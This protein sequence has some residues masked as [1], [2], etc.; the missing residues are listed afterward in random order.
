MKL[1]FSRTVAAL[2]ALAA[3][4]LAEPL[5]LPSEGLE[6]R[7]EFWKKV[8]TQYGEDDIIVHDRFHVNLVYDIAAEFDVNSKVSTVRQAL[9]EIAYNLDAP[10]NLSLPAKQIREAILFRGIPLS[11]DALTE[12]RK[13]IHT[14]RGIKER[15]RQGIVRSGKYVDTFQEILAN[16]GVPE[17]LAL[18]PLVESSFENRSLSKAGAAGIW[19]FTRGTGRLYLKVTPKLDERLDPTKATRAAA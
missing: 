4:A 18:L 11:S 2:L 10:E 6:D 14:Q 5:T 16:E 19:Q 13:N 3:P 9:D 17:Q 15:F 8:Y 1:V 12:L 7:I